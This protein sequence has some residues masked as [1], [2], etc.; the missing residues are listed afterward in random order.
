LALK[1]LSSGHPR[2]VPKGQNVALKLDPPL[3]AY[4]PTQIANGLDRPTTQ[5][6]A[7]AAALDDAN[8]QIHLQW[9]QPETI[10]EIVLKF[11][12]DYD[13]A[14]ETVLLGHP[15]N[16]MPFCVRDY[17]V[18]DASGTV[19][20]EC[21]GNH[22]TINRILLDTPVTTDKLTLEVLATNGDTPGAVFAVHC[23]NGS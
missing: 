8:P 23:Y 17:R 15:E 6:N 11:D 20:A 3:A 18:R 22:Q 7:W 2:A 16:V 4:D 1:R 21:S 14:M 5:T 12:T 19:L 13:H 10:H 9:R